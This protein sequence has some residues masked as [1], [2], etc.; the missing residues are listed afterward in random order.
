MVTVDHKVGELNLGLRR[1]VYFNEKLALFGQLMG[2]AKIPFQ[3]SSISYRRSLTAPIIRRETKGNF[4][5]GA[6]LGLSIKDRYQVAL[7]YLPSQDYLQPF[8][9]QFTKARSISNIMCYR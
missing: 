6:G 9:N 3:N 7:E 8:V 5:V 1:Y 2:S 4:A